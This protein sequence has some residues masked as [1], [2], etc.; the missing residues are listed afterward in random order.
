MLS[1]FECQLESVQ[2]HLLRGGLPLGLAVGDVP[3]VR[4]RHHALVA[5]A[6]DDLRRKETR[7]SEK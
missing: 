4:Q 5:A 6:A 3:L 2:A 1:T 7:R